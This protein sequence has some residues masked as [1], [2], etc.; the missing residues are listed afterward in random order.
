M[1]KDR[2]N[3]IYNRNKNN[4]HQFCF[5]YYCEEKPQIP[6]EVFNQT[7]PMYLMMVNFGDIDG[8]YKKIES[9]LKNKFA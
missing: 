6:L 2:F 5:E 9:F 1:T 3:E 7:F 8:A 4:L